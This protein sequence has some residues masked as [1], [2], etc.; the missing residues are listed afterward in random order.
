MPRA[1][2]CAARTTTPSSPPSDRLKGRCLPAPF[3]DLPPSVALPPIGSLRTGAA[4]SPATARRA[5]AHRVVAHLHDPLRPARRSHHHTIIATI[6]PSTGSLRT[7]LDLSS[8][9]PRRMTG[10]RVVAHFHDPHLP[11]A[12]P[13]LHRP[14]PPAQHPGLVQRR[15]IPPIGRTAG[16]QTV[17][18]NGD[19]HGKQGALEWRSS[20]ILVHRRLVNVPYSNHPTRATQTATGG[21]RAPPID[22]TLQTS[23]PSPAASTDPRSH[24]R[25]PRSVAT[26]RS[27]WEGRRR[28][29]P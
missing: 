13:R 15:A 18:G 17:R 16:V 24:A 21:T 10:Y 20:A 11:Q 5:T 22:R 28:T 6:Q 27:S 2:R 7:N 3:A 9:A 26:S 12:K 29:A 14:Q 8:P 4:R 19:G 1:A 25:R 23:E